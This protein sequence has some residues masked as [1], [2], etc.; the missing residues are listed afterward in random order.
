MKPLL[1][2][3][4]NYKIRYYK[5]M[6]IN[7]LKNNV[8]MTISSLTMYIFKLAIRILSNTM[9]DTMYGDN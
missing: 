4:V 8:C 6:Q 5:I 3:L 2:V 7:T 9:I 1:F